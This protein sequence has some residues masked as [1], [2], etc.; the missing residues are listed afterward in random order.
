[1]VLCATGIS[2][3]S[4][5]ESVAMF[6]RHNMTFAV[7]SFCDLDEC[8]G[9]KSQFGVGAQPFVKTNIKK[10][11]LAIRKTVDIIIVTVHWGKEYY[12]NVDSERKSNARFLASLGVDIVLGHHPH[13]LQDHEII[14]GTFITYRY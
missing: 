9:A 8:S 1:M 4:H 6:V 14:G 11:V 13:V 7:M 3:K 2:N 10:L 12:F 5:G